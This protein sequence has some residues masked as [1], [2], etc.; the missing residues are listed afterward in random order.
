[1]LRYVPDAV[2]VPS[3]AL[4]AALGVAAALPLLVLV[5]GIMSDSHDGPSTSSG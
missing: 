2:G 1:L 3:P 5:P 4:A